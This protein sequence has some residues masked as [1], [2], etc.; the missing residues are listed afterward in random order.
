MKRLMVRIVTAG[1]FLACWGAA[2]EAS[3]GS[4]RYYDLNILM[5][6]PHPF[7]GPQ[8]PPAFVPGQRPEM[9]ASSRRT[10]QET[11]RGPKGSSRR[12]AG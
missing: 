12:P 7:A 10:A 3:S 11:L 4:P 5:Q 1:L 2:F 6:Q 8:A 9:A